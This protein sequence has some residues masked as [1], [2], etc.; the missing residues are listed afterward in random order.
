MLRLVS[1]W[2][3][4][5]GLLM[6]P[7]WLSAAVG[8]GG[9]TAWLALEA[10]LIVGLFALLPRRTWTRVLAWTTALGLVL[11]TFV[12]FVD[13]VFQVSLARSLNL[14]LD[15]YLVGAVYH[16]AVGNSGLATTVA[17]FAGVAVALALATLGA[18][19]VLD[20]R[21]RRGGK[22][23]FSPASEEAR[24]G[25]GGDLRAGAHG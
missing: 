1:G 6:S 25:V 2:V 5:N 10:S 14:F 22:A 20:A 13:V 11:A 4:V 17:G 19:M 7:L 23:G 12:G 15:L 21:R 9:G 8:D 18:G 16:L 3:L 24:R